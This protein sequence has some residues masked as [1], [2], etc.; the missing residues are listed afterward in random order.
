VGCIPR[1]EEGPKAGEPDDDQIEQCGQRLIELV[2]ICKPKLIVCV[3][4]LARNWLTPGMKDS[5]DLDSKIPR[6]DII[7]PAAILRAPANIRSLKVQE[8]I[9]TVNNAV[10]E[11]VCQSR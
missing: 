11:I 10:E 7:H 8:S 1:S 3:G 9:V 2:E 5:I 4:R 6:V